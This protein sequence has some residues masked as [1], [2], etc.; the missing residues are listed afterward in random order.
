V[1]HIA[2]NQLIPRVRIADRV[3]HIGA[4]NQPFWRLLRV[5]STAPSLA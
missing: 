4:G 1:G 3:G 2:C 5:F